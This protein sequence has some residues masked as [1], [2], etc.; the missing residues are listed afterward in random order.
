MADDAVKQAHEAAAAAAEAAKALK[1]QAEAAI[2]A[3]EQAE[4]RAR[5]AEQAAAETAADV[6]DEA[7]GEAARAG[8]DTPQAATRPPESAAHATSD[9]PLDTERID[10]IRAGY[11]FEGPALE[12]GALVNGEAMPDVQV[13]IPI[14]MTNRHGLV[15]GATG[16][17]KTRTLQVLAEQLSA[18]GVAV[19]AADIKGDLSGVADPGRGATRSC[20]T[21]PPASARTGRP[22]AFPA[23]YFSLGGVG[24][25]V[26]IRATIA[27]FGPL[28]L[29]KVLGLN[30]TQESS[31]GLVFHYADK[32]GLRC[33]TSNDLRAVL[34]YLV[35]RRRQG[36]A[37]GARWAVEGDRRGHPA[38]AHHLRRPGRRRLL[39]RTRDRH[40]RVP[41]H[42]TRR[43][44][45]HQPARGAG[46]RRQAGAVLDVPHVAARR[47][48]Q[49][50][51][52]GGRPR[53]AQARVLL[54]RGAPA[55]QGRVEG[56]PRADHPDRAAHPLEGRRHLLRDPDPER[57]ARRRARPARLPGAAPAAGVHARRREGPARRPCRPTRSRATTSKRRSPCSAPARRSSRS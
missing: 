40:R 8:L 23:E 1:A 18:A 54:R 17:G 55:L 2:K 33:S 56:L 19:F 57:R 20:S 6:P 32:N 46:R 44:R 13:R 38:R 16:T 37:R 45:H 11:A 26:P 5:A 36:R 7:S 28:L 34:A 39:R 50:P 3:A 24:R 53:Q 29:S 22:H 42:R 30:D 9:G 12:M 31:L 41:A 52:R 14:A 35:E 25:G 21:A 51:A 4:A 47:P 15:A 27:G 43:A 49:R 10:A 48:V